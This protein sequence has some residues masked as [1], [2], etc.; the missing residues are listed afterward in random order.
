MDS[1]GQVKLDI[2]VL[3]EELI[4]EAKAAAKEAAVAAQKEANSVS[5]TFSNSVGR[6]TS[7]LGGL[8][9]VAKKAAGVLGVAF[10]AVKVA[11]FGKACVDLG[12]DLAEVQNV[13]DVVYGNMSSDVESFAQDAIKSYGISE[14]VAKEYMGTMGSMSKAFGFSTKDAYKQAES[15]TALAGDMASF[16]N[17]STDETFTALKAV[18]SGETEVLKKYG[19]VMSET[20]LNEYAMSNGIGKTVKAMSEQEKVSLR[21]SF[22]Q[23]RL[24]AATGDFSRTSG[25]WANQ[26][27]ILTLRWEEFKSS[28]GQGLIN[29]LTPLI[30]W[31][32]EVMVYV[33]QLAKDFAYCTALLMG[34]DPDNNTFGDMATDIADAS[35]NT[36]A[37][38]KGIKGTT[39]AVKTLKRQLAAFD[40]L[41]V[42]SNPQT[43]GGGSSG[44]GSDLGGLPGI[45][46]NGNG[47]STGGSSSGGSGGSLDN[48][49]YN[50]GSGFFDLCENIGSGFFDLAEKIGKGFFDLSEGIGIKVSNAISD[51]VGDSTSATQK[52]IG[53]GDGIASKVGQVLSGIVGDS[54]AASNKVNGLLEKTDKKIRQTNNLLDKTDEKAKETDSSASG[55]LNSGLSQLLTK[56]HI[57]MSQMGEEAK[58]NGEKIG[59][60]YQQGIMSSIGEVKSAGGKL[61]QAALIPLQQVAGKP[62][63]DCAKRLDDSYYEGI[64]KNKGK[65]KDGSEEVA[66]DAVLAPFRQIFGTMKTESKTAGSDAG[67]AIGQGMRNEKPLILREASSV[68]DEIKTPFSKNGKASSYKD[69]VKSGN[70]VVDGL[71]KGVKDKTSTLLKTMKKLAEKTVSQFNKSAKI[72]S[73]SKV[74]ATSGMFLVEG[75]NKGVEDNIASSEKTVKNWFNAIRDTSNKF[76]GI[77]S[78]F[79]RNNTPQLGFVG[80]GNYRNN[81]NSNEN[82]TNSI[83]NG[84]SQVMPQLMALLSSISRNS[85]SSTKNTGLPPIH[86]YMDGREIHDVVFDYE[87]RNNSRSGGRA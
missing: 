86:L 81:Y 41:N 49:F 7:A 79:V 15:L 3:K 43:G 28:I 46:G 56:L 82:I 62:S 19:V 6:G 26:V 58:P 64:I 47:S 5:K 24:S 51:I 42:L 85:G 65:V 84:M 54:S 34:V 60:N 32:N 14:K 20:A 40:K 30:T 29:V 66:K 52:I 25:G 73:P 22:V 1:V 38:N 69:L 31:L 48:M 76:P 57:K 77:T 36:K 63:G 53:L 83:V 74:F 59:D 33:N 13:V 55:T 68:V 80:E 44:G 12:S 75:L 2:K 9:S 71:D 39:G 21:L 11:N 23:D 16:Y 87:N 35:Q 61:A 37:L 10:S 50:I 8:T 27:K 70:N 4:Q 45:S 72:Q 78:D 18:Y 17:K 67:D